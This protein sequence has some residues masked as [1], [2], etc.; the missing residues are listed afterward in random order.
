M[1][2]GKPKARSRTAITLAAMLCLSLAPATLAQPGAEAIDA[3][4]DLDEQASREK[5]LFVIRRH[6]RSVGGEDALRAA[7]HI[8]FEGKFQIKGAPFVGRVQSQRAVPGRQLTRLDLGQNGTILQGY[9]GQIAWT[10]HPTT[11]PTLLEGPTAHALARNANPQAD[12]HYETNYTRIEYLGDAEFEGEPAFAI[13]LTDPF[14]A[15]TTE[16]FSKGRGTRIGVAGE[17][18]SADGPVPYTRALLDYRV[19]ERLHLPTR[20]VERFGRQEITLTVESVS[21]APIYES[22]FQPPPSVQALIES[23][24][25]DGS[26]QAD[27]DAP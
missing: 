22:A 19:F 2:P 13:R 10:V 4:P 9:D 18:P 16:Y 6:I 26:D 23:E 25:K 11:G 27:E 12:L 15:V 14:G 24:R 7:T 5:A 20:T 17:R 1:R 21:F 3:Q 8:A